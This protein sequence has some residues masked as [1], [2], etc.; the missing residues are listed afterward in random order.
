M[1][2]NTSKIVEYALVILIGL[3]VSYVIFAQQQS[4]KE[5]FVNLE[6]RLQTVE[7]KLDNVEANN[8]IT[9]LRLKQL[10]EKVN[11]KVEQPTNPEGTPAPTENK[12]EK[13]ANQK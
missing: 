10:D 3:I 4:D 5:R 11:P 8:K 12:D 1:K 9:E 13:P 6:A 2:E 7:Q